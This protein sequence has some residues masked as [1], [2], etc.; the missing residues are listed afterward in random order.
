MELAWSS[1]VLLTLV[2]IL[3]YVYGTWPFSLW[4]Q[5]GL[6]GPTPLPFIGNAWTIATKGFFNATLEWGQKYGKTYRIYLMREPMLITNDLDIL[7]E[8]FVKDFNNFSFRAPDIPLLP[9]PVDLGVSLVGGDQWKRLRNIMNPSF[10]SCKLKMMDCFVK[11][12]CQNLITSIDESVRQG[13]PLRVKELFGAYTLDVIAGTG[14]GLETNSQAEDDNTFLNN[15]KAVLGLSS[16]VTLPAVLASAFPFLVPALKW[17][18]CSVLPDKET[19]FVVSTI[20]KLVEDRRNHSKKTSPD[21]MQLMLNA[22]ASGAETNN[23]LHEKSL[24]TDEIVSQGITFFVAGYDTT[25]ISLQFLFYLLAT[26]P[27]VQEKLYRAIVD[28][29]GDEKEASY[30]NVKDIPYLDCCYR[31]ALRLFPPLPLIARKASE[32]RTIHGVKIP[33]GSSVGTSIYSLMKDEHYFPNPHV[34]RPERFDKKN[35]D[36]IPKLLSD[37]VFGVGP[38]QCIGKRLALYEAKMAVVSVLRHFR[39]V[40]IKETPETIR[41]AADTMCTSDKP[42]LIGCQ[43]RH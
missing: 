14:L 8:V 15:A 10:S 38:R 42:I 13:K 28:E 19:R 1:I 6:T 24:S 17:L 37:I 18:G 34:F 12:C 16:L 7:K 33:A 5:H 40:K 23:N 21:L 11:R 2:I 36:R 22:E 9:Y 26:N 30:E 35:Q 41:L 25:S 4:S 29:I 32:E 20:Q 31:E 39:F 3:I 27:P 43:R